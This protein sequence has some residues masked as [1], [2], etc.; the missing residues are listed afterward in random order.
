MREDG[1][2]FCITETFPIHPVGPTGEHENYFG[3]TSNNS[4]CIHFISFKIHL[5][6]SDNSITIYE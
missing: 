5:I 6:T 4:D 1:V 2:F 3:K